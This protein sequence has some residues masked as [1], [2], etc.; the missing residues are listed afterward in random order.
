MAKIRIY[1][2]KN[3]NKK[4]IYK[5]QFLR[6]YKRKNNLS[7]VQ[8]KILEM[9]YLVYI[10]PFKIYIILKNLRGR[11]DNYKTFYKEKKIINHFIISL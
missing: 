6:I 1:L 7:V 8:W 10:K 11:K 5:N 4:K 3:N 2:K 9:F